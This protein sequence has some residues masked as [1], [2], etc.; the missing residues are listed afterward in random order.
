[1]RKLKTIEEIRAGWRERQARWRG[2][3]KERKAWERAQEERRARKKEKKVEV[4]M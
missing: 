1:M 3:Q 4:E 2:R